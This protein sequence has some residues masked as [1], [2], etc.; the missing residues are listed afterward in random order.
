[1][2]SFVLPSESTSDANALSWTSS[3]LMILPTWH[4][5]T[6][7]CRL[8]TI[9]SSPS[10]VQFCFSYQ[11]YNK[12]L[13]QSRTLGFPNLFSL[14]PKV[15]STKRSPKCKFGHCLQFQTY[16]H[17]RSHKNIPYT[18]TCRQLI[19]YAVQ[20]SGLRLVYLA[21]VFSWCKLG[22]AITEFLWTSPRYQCPDLVPLIP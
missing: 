14:L 7:L 1:M 5:N 17:T 6:S 13:L 19:C 16:V 20:D 8:S 3:Q 18:L 22:T 15:L 12:C 21:P 4:P 9:S 11:S 10:T 2:T